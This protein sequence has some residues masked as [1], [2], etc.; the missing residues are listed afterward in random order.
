MCNEIV[1]ANREKYVISTFVQ[2][3]MG[4]KACF[5][6]FIRRTVIGK[7]RNLCYPQVH[8]NVR[9]ERLVQQHSLH[10][11][12]CSTSLASSEVPNL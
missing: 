10:C 11:Y 9:I 12:A 3:Y 7:Y 4:L 8:F 6:P 2:P 1:P 5:S